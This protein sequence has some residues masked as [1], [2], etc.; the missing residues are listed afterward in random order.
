MTLP[1]GPSDPPKAAPASV[2]E[3]PGAEGARAS[4][5]TESRSPR[6]QPEPAP[7]GL[8]YERWRPV[9]AGAALGVAL[10]LLFMG[11]PGGPY[12]AMSAAFM[13]LVPMAVGAVTV[14]VAERSA[15]RSWGYWV[16][17]SIAA[18]T[19][20]VL[21]TFLIMIEGLICAVIALPLFLA[22]GAL[23]GLLM[24]AVCRFTLRR[25]PA[26]Y[27]LTL[28]PLVLGALPERGYEPQRMT[29]LERSVVIQAPAARVW[30]E[31]HQASDIRPHEVDRAWMY[32][33]GVP[34][35][36]SG[37]TEQHGQTLVRRV[38]MGKDIHFD[39]VATQWQENRFVHWTYR[40]EPDSIPPGALDDHVE[41]GGHYF[42]LLDTR[43]EL[44]PLGEESTRLRIRMRYRVSTEFNAY[45]DAVGR[46]LVGNFE[47]VI[48][49]FYRH[50]A[51]QAVQRRG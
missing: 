21:G 16:R 41:I 26:L 36:L 12:A 40:F 46:L 22:L 24:G 6:P 29:A 45:A 2:S 15:P 20:F 34:L 31:L 33:I 17:S 44:E 38:R 13:I 43:Y 14:Y 32:R 39:Q 35:P 47:E 27:S 48:L 25:K 1:H 51:M 11:E 30:R 28:L 42:D 37:V 50:R 7:A 10:R 49:E 3:P 23:G 4:P 19:F 8:P 9:L 5:A 18:T